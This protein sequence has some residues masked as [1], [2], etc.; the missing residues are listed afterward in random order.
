MTAWNRWASAVAA[1]GG[2]RLHPVGHLTLRDVDWLLAQL[3]Q[4]ATAGVRLA[5]IAPIPTI[6]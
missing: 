4:L 1:E 5:M 3:G 2:G 6:H